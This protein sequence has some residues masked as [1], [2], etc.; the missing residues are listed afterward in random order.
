[1]TG[2][3]A[4]ES[5]T[6]RGQDV[7]KDEGKEPGRYDLRR[8]AS[9]SGRSAA[10]RRAPLPASIRRKQSPRIPQRTKLA[11]TSDCWSGLPVFGAAG[12]PCPRDG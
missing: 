2:G 4:G 6:Q 5:I 11:E 12:T 3:H 7:V 10:P 1:M 9:P 8:R